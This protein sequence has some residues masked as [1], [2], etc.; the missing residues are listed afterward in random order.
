MMHPVSHEKKDLKTGT[1]TTMSGDGSLM[2]SLNNLFSYGIG[3]KDRIVEDLYNYLSRIDLF[4]DHSGYFFS[5]L[6][7]FFNH[8]DHFSNEVLSNIQE[9]VI[10][11]LKASK[12]IYLLRSEYKTNR[13]LSNLSGNNS[14]CKNIRNAIIEI[15]KQVYS[16]DNTSF[17]QNSMDTKPETA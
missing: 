8:Q 1:K 3:D 15:Q 16:E 2:F 12:N 6:Q 17:N 5:A 9:A 13:I 4:S 14:Y 7:F 11:N 10:E